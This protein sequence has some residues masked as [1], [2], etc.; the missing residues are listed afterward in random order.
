MP[1]GTPYWSSLKHSDILVSMI[2]TSYTLKHFGDLTEL[3]TSIRRQQSL[4]LLEVI[5]VIEKDKDL[6]D[7]T[8]SRLSQITEFSSLILYYSH[9]DGMSEARNKGS[10]FARGKFVAFIDDDVVLDKGW[11]ESLVYTMEKYDP[12]VITGPSHPIWVGTRLDWLP[13]ELSWIVGSTEWFDCHKVT[14]IRN[15]WGN[16]MVVK[17]TEFLQIG[18]FST[19]YGLHS[20]RRRRW[21]DP[22]SEDVDLSLR[23]NQRFGKQVLYVPSMSVGHKVPKRKLSWKFIIQRSYSIGYQRHVIQKIYQNNSANL[24]SLETSLIP[25]LLALWP[26]SLVTLFKSPKKGMNTLAAL[27]IILMFSSLGFVDRRPY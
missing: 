11:L 5:F 16:N 18:G 24:L 26:R 10:E 17:K 3:I 19:K 27:F 25:N 7:K 23:L 4:D 12:I 14:P 2:I 9:L 15:A 8:I 6:F 13:V 21:F 1:D 20:A 22:P